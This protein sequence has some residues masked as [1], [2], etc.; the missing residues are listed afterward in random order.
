MRKNPRDASAYFSLAAL[1]LSPDTA[2]AID[3][4][5]EGLRLKPD[6]PDALNNLAWIRA[7]HPNPAFRN[8]PE[9]VQLAQQACEL[10]RF[11]RPMLVGTLAAAYAEAGRF[12][13]AIATAQKA[14]DLALASG[15][16]DLAGQNQKLLELYQAHQPYHDPAEPQQ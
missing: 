8:G 12:D 10:T 2:H 9:A 13:E 14:R 11:Q 1:N 4:Y 16:N 7:A 6:H 5:R 3:Q 15:Q